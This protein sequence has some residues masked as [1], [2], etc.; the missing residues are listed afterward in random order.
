MC[1]DLCLKTVSLPLWCSRRILGVRGS[2]EARSPV[3]GYC[4]D[5][6]ER[7]W[8][9][10]PSAGS[11]DEMGGGIIPWTEQPGRLSSMGS[12]RVRHDLTTK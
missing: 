2:L 5:P 9:S 7:G 12:Q 6:E 10:G 1:S 11:G 4:S 3:R 8:G